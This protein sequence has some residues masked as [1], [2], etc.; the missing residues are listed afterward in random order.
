MNEGRNA[1][2][3]SFL[4]A[5]DAS[6]SS[7]SSALQRGSYHLLQWMRHVRPSPTHPSRPRIYA[8]PALTRHLTALLQVC[9]LRHGAQ[10]DVCQRTHELRPMP[11]F[12][13]MRGYA[14]AHPP[15]TTKPISTTSG[16]SGSSAL[17]RGSYHLLQ[18]MHHVRPSPTHPSRPRIYAAPTLTRHLTALLQV[19]LLRHGARCGVC[20]RTHK[21]R[22]MPR[23]LR[24]RGYASAHP[25]K[26]TKTIS[27]T[28]RSFSNPSGHSAA[29]G[30]TTDAALRPTL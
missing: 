7:G 30:A 21:L 15:K 26:T 28:A 10:C 20:Q 14:S 27:T 4:H 16:F 18:W 3:P 6:G 11:R 9:L 25:P 1:P 5:C 23:F 12:L 22:P 29:A 17:Q 8:A 2:P 13:R 19:C 24:M